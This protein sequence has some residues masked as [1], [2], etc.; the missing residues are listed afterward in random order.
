MRTNGRKEIKVI[1]KGEE[2]GE[3]VEEGRRNERR[4]RGGRNEKAP[5]SKEKKFNEGRLLLKSVGSEAAP[6][7]KAANRRP[8]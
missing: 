3:K 6:K 2:E 7:R 5:P 8:T 1:G 4:E